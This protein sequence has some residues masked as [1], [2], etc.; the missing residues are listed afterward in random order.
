M[1]YLYS[2]F[3]SLSVPEGTVAGDFHTFLCIANPG[4]L[5]PIFDH[6]FSSLKGLSHEMEGGYKSG[7]NVKVSLNPI[8]AE[9]KKV[10]LLKGLF[11]I[12]I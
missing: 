3:F 7:I 6:I 8:A 9:A 5:S 10:I 1:H 12:Y 2:Y 11:T 4:Q